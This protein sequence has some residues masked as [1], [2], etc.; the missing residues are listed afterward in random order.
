MSETGEE[1]RR[2]TRLESF[3]ATGPVLDELMAYTSRLI[4]AEAIGSTEMED[5]RHLEAWL[6]YAA[7]AEEG[8]AVFA[9][10][11][12]FAQLRFPIAEGMSQD[13]AYRAATRKGQFSRAQGYEPGLH[14]HRPDAITLSIQTTMAGKIPILVAPER[15]DFVALVRAFTERNE[16]APVPDSMGACI[17]SGLNNWDRIRS[18]RRQW[19]SEQTRAVGDVEWAAEFRRLIPQK[20]RYQDRFIILSTGP[21]SAV[22]ATDLGLD[23]DEWLR[24]SLLIR[25]EHEC[26]H[27]F[28]LR[29]FGSMKNHALDEL[30]ADFV[31]LV[32]ARGTYR[33]AEAL[34]FLGLGAH[35][36]YREGGRLEAYLGDPELSVE[37]FGILREVVVRAAENLERVARERPDLLGDLSGLARL[38]RALAALGLVELASDEID[39]CA[40]DTLPGPA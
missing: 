4:V 40:H 30:F 22:P 10:R 17:V 32:R 5:E 25:R 31:G 1:R 35:P 14:L 18:H 28:T 26:M 23:D 7:Q 11:E 16:P 20:D 27:Y 36:E 15:E 19:E 24:Q 8:G 29:A 6:G 39:S 37:A 3:G 34:R 12:R 9:L 38:M 2:R 33:A 21:Y 13:E